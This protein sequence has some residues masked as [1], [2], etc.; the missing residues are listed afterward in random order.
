MRTYKETIWSGIAGF[1]Y[2]WLS[3]GAE[4]NEEIKQAFA[5][6]MLFLP[7]FSFPF[8]TTYDPIMVVGKDAR[9]VP[10]LILSALI[11]HGNTW[12]FSLER[13]YPA[14]V[15]AT[16]FTGSLFYLMMTKWMFS[17]PMPFQSILLIALLSGIS[18]TGFVWPGKNIVPIGIGVF[19]W[20]VLNGY[21]LN[22]IR[23]RRT[24]TNLG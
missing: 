23:I 21:Y 24:A 10:H 4:Y 22:L 2:L 15:V 6:V 1:F 20:T 9:I 18:F 16:G 13:R 14:I 7:G 5:I 12:I 11:Y 8:T 17:L 19:L 3:I